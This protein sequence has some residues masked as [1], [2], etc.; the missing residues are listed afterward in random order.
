[1]HSKMIIDVFKT[2]T[3]IRYSALTERCHLYVVFETTVYSLIL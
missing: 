2:S 3:E 1:M